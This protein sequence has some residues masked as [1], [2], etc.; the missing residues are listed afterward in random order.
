M[1]SRYNVYDF[2]RVREVP[3]EE[4]NAKGFDVRVYAHT[5]KGKKKY[6]EMVMLH[7]SDTV[8]YL[9]EIIAH[10]H[11]LEYRYIQFAKLS[12]IWGRIIWAVCRK[13]VYEK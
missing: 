6:M 3:T 7:K 9:K 4:K 13:D 12:C 11:G 5:S 1:R 2:K 10:I 8:E